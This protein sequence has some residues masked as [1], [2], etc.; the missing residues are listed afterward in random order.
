MQERWSVVGASA[1]IAVC[2]WGVSF[3][4]AE[5]H[6]VRLRGDLAGDCWRACSV[7][8]PWDRYLVG[9]PKK[10]GNRGANFKKGGTHHAQRWKAVDGDHATDVAGGA[11]EQ[12]SNSGGLE[13]PRCVEA[14]NDKVEGLVGQRSA[15]ESM[16]ISSGYAG[17][18]QSQVASRGRERVKLRG[19]D[20]SSDDGGGVHPQQVS[21]TR[22]LGE[23]V[24]L[25][26]VDTS[27]ED[28]EGAVGRRSVAERMDVDKS[29]GAGHGRFSQPQRV[30]SN[31]GAV[32][33]RGVDLSSDDEE[34]AQ[35]QRV[36]GRREQWCETLS[37]FFEL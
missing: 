9:A 37:L 31:R 34:G 26:D 13:Q 7:A 17:G 16:G 1:A 21:G 11:S 30:S 3:G 14:S 12:A 8:P 10:K 33:L 2:V 5:E 15:V 4:C 18:A 27:S 19:D 35:P 6:V 25:R 36:S 32:K 28:V 29:S 20:T 23:R 22:G 24:K